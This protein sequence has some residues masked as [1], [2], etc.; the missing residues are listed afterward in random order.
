M[1]YLREIIILRKKLPIG[2]Q[3]AKNL[4]IET[5]GNVVQAENTF[6]ENMINIFMSKESLDKEQATK[7]LEAANYDI[8]IAIKRLEADKYS[9][10]ELCLMKN[11]NKEDALGNIL[12]AICEKHGYNY[13]Y[14]FW[15]SW[16]KDCP[17][18]NAIEYNFVVLMEWINYEA[19]EG[20][21]IIS[22]IVAQVC[23]DLKIQWL[24]DMLNNI[25]NKNDDVEKIWND[26]AY[27]L[28]KDT[29]L[30]RRSEL[31]NILYEYVKENINI[32]P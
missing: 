12:Y 24:E 28:L 11:K 25:I 8:G 18:I 1:E 22:P 9:I 16:A 5:G 26:E 27:V 15:L 7:Y 23:H 4:L 20:D 30:K 14:N 6:M 13:D 31:I 32:F 3:H 19:W 29:F 10:T 17:K 21:I 2:I